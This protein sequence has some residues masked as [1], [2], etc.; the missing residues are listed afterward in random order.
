M[1]PTA[2]AASC[3]SRNPARS[4]SNKSLP[5][6]RPFWVCLFCDDEELTIYQWLR[7]IRDR[8]NFSE[9]RDMKISPVFGQ[10]RARREACLT[11]L[12]SPWRDNFSMRVRMDLRFLYCLAAA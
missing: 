10:A 5:K 11:D 9:G 6:E 3:A 4:P 12:D 1:P 2:P 8:G 7:L